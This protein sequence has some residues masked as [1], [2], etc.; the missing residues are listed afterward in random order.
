LRIT[1]WGDNRGLPDPSFDHYL[2]HAD[3]LVLPI[4]SVLTRAEVDAIVGKYDP[5]AVIPA[6]YFLNSLTTGISGL[7]SID[8]WVND[9]EKIHHDDVRRLNRADLTLNT[10]ELRGSHHR[11][12][13]FGDHFKR[14]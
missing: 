8:S 14:K 7:E 9:Q 11:V 3:V 4:E 2:N 6:H 1:V 13:Y 12:Y 5:R 10:A